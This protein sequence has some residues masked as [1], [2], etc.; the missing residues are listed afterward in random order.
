MS[1]TKE[2]TEQFCACCNKLKLCHMYVL[3]HG[4]AEFVCDDCREGK[5]K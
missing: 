1:L 3:Q 2:K 4:L 5:K